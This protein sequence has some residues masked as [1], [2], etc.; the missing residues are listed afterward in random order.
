MD[1]ALKEQ[2]TELALAT[3]H[4][5]QT[6]RHLQ[7]LISTICIL[8]NNLIKLLKVNYTLNVIQKEL[9]IKLLHLVLELTAEE[10]RGC[11]VPI[12]RST[13]TLVYRTLM[14]RAHDN[15]HSRTMMDKC[16]KNPNSQDNI[17]IHEMDIM[18]T[19]FR[20]QGDKVNFRVLNCPL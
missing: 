15:K 1:L 3:V 14:S 6:C 12:S 18:L 20:L 10:A 7:V 16:M 17:T 8:I 2:D 13:E 9:S 4:V 11:R 5:K 19:R